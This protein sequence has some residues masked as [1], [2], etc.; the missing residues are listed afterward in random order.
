MLTQKFKN[1]L[2]QVIKAYLLKNNIYVSKTTPYSNLV[3]FLTLLKPMQTNYEL[4]RIGSDTD[5]GY[6]IPND[7]K[8]I[9]TCFSPGVSTTSDF[10]YNNINII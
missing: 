6:L 9:D 7:L 8:G 10:E 2:K 1:R 3:S 5:G 4:I